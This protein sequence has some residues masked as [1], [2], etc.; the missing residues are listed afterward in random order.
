MGFGDNEGESLNYARICFNSQLHTWPVAGL[1]RNA[2]GLYDMHGNVWEWCQDEYDARI[3]TRGVRRKTRRVQA[4][5]AGACC[6][7]ARGEAHPRSA[8]LHSATT[9]SPAS[10]TTTRLSC[11]AGR[12]ASC[13]RPDRERGE[14]QTRIDGDRSVYRRRRPAHRR[15]AG[16]AAGRGGAERVDAAQPRLRRQG[17]AQDRGRRRHGI[18]DRDR[19]GNGHLARFESSTPCGCSMAPARGPTSPTG[20]WRT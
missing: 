17:G 2:W 7:A 15:P 16:R 8:A 18:L 5:T 1:K 13:Q 11:R 12:L 10:A 6:V 19:P 20:Y 3:T 14:G 4:L 9:P